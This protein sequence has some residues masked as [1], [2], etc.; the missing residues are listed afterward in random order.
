MR[1]LKRNF[2]FKACNKIKKIPIHLLVYRKF[3]LH[4]QAYILCSLNNT[5]GN[6]TIEC[7]NLATIVSSR[8]NVARPFFRGKQLSTSAETSTCNSNV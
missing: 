4:K 1:I 8:K 2:E 5:L 7:K 6:N 3:Q